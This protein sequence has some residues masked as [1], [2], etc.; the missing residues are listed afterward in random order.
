MNSSVVK[1][2]LTQ[3]NQAQ[4]RLIQI[5]SFIQKGQDLNGYNINLIKQLS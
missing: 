3:P 4:L 1:R 5:K 2:F